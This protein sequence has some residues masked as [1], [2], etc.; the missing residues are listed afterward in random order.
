MNTQKMKV[1][2]VEDSPSDAEFVRAALAEHNGTSFMV[3]LALRLS[4]AIAQ[5]HQTKMDIVLLDLGLPDSQGL[6]TLEQLYQVFG[7]DTAM[8]VLTSNEDEAL[9]PQA[10]QLGAQDFLNK[11][12]ITNG[13]AL[14]RCLRYGYERKQREV[15]ERQFVQA[16]RDMEVAYQ[17]ISPAGRSLISLD[18]YRPRVN[19]GIWRGAKVKEVSCAAETCEVTVLVN[20]EAQRVKFTNPI[21]ETWILDAGKWWFVYQG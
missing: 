14:T 3:A 21:K 5:L 7:S 1:L 13:S 20:I 4:D 8:V 6:P 9:G 12:H 16:K 18:D 17:F 10:L 15:M 19:A 2:L 11:K